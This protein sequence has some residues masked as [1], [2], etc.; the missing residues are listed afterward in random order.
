LIRSRIKP[1]ALLPFVGVHSKT[2][3]QVWRYTG[4]KYCWWNQQDEGRDLTGT[5]REKAILERVSCITSNS[6]AG[7]D[8]IAATYGIAPE[9][10]LVYNN[11]TPMPDD[12]GEGNI[13]EQ[14]NLGARRIVSMVANVNEFKDHETLIA[15]WPQVRNHFEQGERPMLAL[16]GHLKDR[17]TVK[18]LKLQAFE[19]GLSTDDV[20]FLGPVEDVSKL[21]AA[22]DLVV[23]S[24][25]TEGCP[26]AVCE[27]MALGRAVVATDIAGCRQAL[28]PGGAEF[29]AAPRDAGALAEQII[30]MLDDD[31][32]RKSAGVANHTRIADD[33]SIPEM[34]RFFQR[35]IEEGL[36]VSLV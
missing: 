21:M 16:A 19:L 6:I 12:Y 2:M 20:R 11:G 33:F 23:H 28:G 17:V 35:R 25:L 18:R 9:R 30:R 15:A 34:N 26:N 24:S 3:A 36:G 32:L 5:P 14:L 22:S 10:V 13:R 8:F 4:A 29:L 1:D 7:R 31:A 27:A